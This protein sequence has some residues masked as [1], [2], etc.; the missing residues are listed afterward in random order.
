MKEISVIVPVYN[1]EEHVRECVDSIINQSFNCFEI[2]LVDDGSTDMSG[3]ICDTYAEFD[4]RIRVIHKSNEGVASARNLGLK[5][6]EGNYIAFI[7]SDDIVEKTYLERLYNALIQTD[8]DLAFCNYT[9]FNEPSKLEC[10]SW[11]KIENKGMT[12]R[13]GINKEQVIVDKWEAFHDYFV[14]K[15]WYMCT[16]W[17][18][19]V[20][21]DFLKNQEFRKME[22]A[23]DE[24]FVIECVLRNPK[25]ILIPY[26][27]YG[28]MRWDSSVT[29]KVGDINIQQ[30]INL[31]Y[32]RKMI[33]QSS[34]LD[35]SKKIK[36]EAL[37]CY[38]E[39]LYFTISFLVKKGDFEYYLENVEKLN[40]YI[41]DCSRIVKIRLKYRI[42]FT[43]LRND[44]LIYWK[45]LRFFYRWKKKRIK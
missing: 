15:R 11:E 40:H 6:A 10:M 14:G 24:T 12:K 41:D 43:I 35:A 16:V 19:L 42:I 13:G 32:G 8:S 30:M 26:C 22:Y 5:F 3:A 1:A 45:V 17:G 44:N 21:K 2:I 39:T 9:E 20:K 18:M 37:L 33:Y 7:D 4:A 28:Y 38:A 23:E 27:G 25:I 36:E 29:K 31:L 34:K